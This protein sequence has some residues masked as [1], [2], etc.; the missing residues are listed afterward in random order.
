MGGCLLSLLLRIPQRSS[1]SSGHRRSFPAGSSAPPS[2]FFRQTHFPTSL[3]VPLGQASGSQSLGPLLASVLPST[4]S[5]QPK[6]TCPRGPAPESP[7][8]PCSAQQCPCLP[9]LGA[10]LGVGGGGNS[11]NVL[12]DLVVKKVTQALQAALHDA[13]SPPAA[14]PPFSMTASSTFIAALRAPEPSPA[15]PSQEDLSSSFP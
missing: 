15:S 3:S 11:T 2:L 10:S 5:Q 9:C 8:L 7:C 13:T 14:P 1:P 6:L 12:T 4:I